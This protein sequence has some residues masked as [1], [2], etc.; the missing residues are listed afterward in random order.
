MEPPWLG[1][2]GTASGPGQRDAPTGTRQVMPGS[3]P[4]AA[5][6]HEQPGPPAEEH[7]G[8][9]E[10]GGEGQQAQQV[11]LVR[12]RFAGGGAVAWMPA[13]TTSA[14]ATLADPKATTV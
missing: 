2:Q 3:V 6:Q 14:E 10:H 13:T 12:G 9:D 1:H 4:S 11:E 8:P 5:T 7:A